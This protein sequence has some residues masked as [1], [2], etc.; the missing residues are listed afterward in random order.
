[1]SH[2]RTTPLFDGLRPL[3]AV[4]AWLVLGHG[5]SAPN[6]ALRRSE[7]ADRDLTALSF[8]DG[9]PPPAPAP[10]APDAGAADLAAADLM[11]ADAAPD[12]TSDLAA[13][14]LVAPDSTF[15]TAAPDLTFDLAGSDLAAPDL[16]TP[17]LGPPACGALDGVAGACSRA[18]LNLMTG[19]SGCGTPHCCSGCLA[20]QPAGLAVQYFDGWRCNFCETCQQTNATTSS[21]RWC[22]FS[23]PFAGIWES[24]S[25]A[26]CCPAACDRRSCLPNEVKCVP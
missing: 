9:G 16:M 11:A 15:D 3:A 7:P 13:P 22:L 8:R 5:C 21:G 2:A 12:L 6:D 19:L 14:D 20:S 26:G 25:C 4:V 23:P 10:S 17:D 24:N 18:G 1:M